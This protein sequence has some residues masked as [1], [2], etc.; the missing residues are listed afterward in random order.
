MKERT[1][2]PSSRAGQI[3]DREVCAPGGHVS[4]RGEIHP[5]QIALRVFYKGLKH[6]YP[7]TYLRNEIK[8][9]KSWFTKENVTL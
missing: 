1:H 8:G 2:L 6:T 4:V 5:L 7:R 3:L 9:Q